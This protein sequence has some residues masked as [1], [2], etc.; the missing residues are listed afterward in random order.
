M[1]TRSLPALSF[2]LL[3]ACVSG[4]GQKAA[5]P[6]AA[7]PQADQAP[8]A[9]PAAKEETVVRLGYQKIGSPFLLKDRATDLKAA[10]TKH[11]ARAE[12]VE[13]QAGP[14]LLEAMRAGAVDIGYVG[15]TPPVFAQAGGVPFVYIAV[16]A[17]APAAEAIVV[18]K[19]S[20]V[21]SVAELEGKKI[22]VN[23]GSNVH[24]LLVKALES[25]KLAITDVQVSYLAPP[26]ARAAFDTGQVD[27]WVIW[28]P[29]Y[30]A[31]E[32]AGARTLVDGKGLVDN[33]LFYV[34][35]REYAEKNPTLVNVVLDEYERISAW[36]KTNPE[37]VA[38]ILAA[39]S[40]IA[41]EALL[42]AEKRHAYDVRP[43]EPETLAQQQ[44]IADTFFELQLIPQSIKTAD[45][46]LSTTRFGNGS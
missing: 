41:Y 35:R 27:A 39:S 30:A 31:A 22:A 24:Y 15:E 3:L 33:Q 11:N 16:D 20:K 44:T 21:Q 9:T 46:F 1:S 38:K 36:A 43:I 6:T 37:E 42:L 40:G 19:N 25:A 28:D 4:C 7:A 23:R 13:F 10:L 34:A 18:P 8:P 45:A 29:F 14:P 2:S 17:P 32:V 5:E 12:W 26:D